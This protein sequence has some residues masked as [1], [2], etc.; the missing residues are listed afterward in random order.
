[1]TLPQHRS[2]FISFSAVAP[3]GW[4]SEGVFKVAEYTDG[5][6]WWELRRILPEVFSERKKVECHRL[7]KAE[8]QEWKK[9]WVECGFEAR[10][11]L[12]PSMRAHKAMLLLLDDPRRDAFDIPGFGVQEQYVRNEFMMRTDGLILVLAFW[13][14]SARRQ[15]TRSRAEAMLLAMLAVLPQSALFELGIS[16]VLDDH[17]H[18]CPMVR[19]TGVCEHVEPLRAMAPLQPGVALGQDF[20]RILTCLLGARQQCVAAFGVLRY[21]IDEVT[22]AFT[23]AF[24]DREPGD[25]TKQHDLRGS[26]KRRRLDEDLKSFVAGGARRTGR[27]A[28]S[29]AAAA[30]FLSPTSESLARA[31]SQEMNLKHMSACW[32]AFSEQLVG[33]VS[34]APDATRLGQPAKDYLVSPIWYAHVDGAAWLPPQARLPNQFQTQSGG[35]GQLLQVQSVGR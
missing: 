26:V 10:W 29:G 20:V 9:L 3:D 23:K 24:A 2:H 8:F 12:S 6:V 22:N 18:R 21:L 31:W 35:G 5:S 19:P 14:V 34:I 32:E 13:V 28:S 11:L 7:V 27:S 33:V 25:P 1:M 4:Q 30:A 16:E 17:A 15:A